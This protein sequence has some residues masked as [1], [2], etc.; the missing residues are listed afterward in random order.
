MSLDD[1]GRPVA[2]VGIGGVVHGFARVLLEAEH[3]FGDVRDVDGFAVLTSA[4]A[5]AWSSTTASSAAPTPGPRR[6]RRGEPAAV[7]TVL[8]LRAG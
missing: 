7:P 3:R 5:S 8:A 1:P 6:S 2:P 4:P